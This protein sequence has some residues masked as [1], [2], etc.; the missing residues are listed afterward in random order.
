MKVAVAVVANSNGGMVTTPRTDRVIDR[1][2]GCVVRYG[3]C[4]PQLGPSSADTK[5]IDTGH[6][7]GRGQNNQRRKLG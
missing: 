4:S 6:R 3:A 7:Q 2:L 1:G 5:T